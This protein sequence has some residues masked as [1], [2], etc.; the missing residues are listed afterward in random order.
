MKK[1]NYTSIIQESVSDLEELRNSF[2]NKKLIERCEILIWLKSGQIKTMKECMKL[3]SRSISH[4]RDLWKLYKTEGLSGYLQL[5]YNPQVSPL[6]GKTE[7]IERLKTE[8]FSTINEAR[9]WILNTYNIR[10]TENGLG[11]YFRSHHI[12]LKTGRPKHPKQDEEKREAYKKN[13]RKN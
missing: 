10:Y 4:G 6:E 12:K 5:N 2:S 8:G 13:T 11:N 7:L 1:V 9:L 3:K